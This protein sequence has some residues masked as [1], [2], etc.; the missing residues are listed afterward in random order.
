MTWKVFGGT[1]AD[2]YWSLLIHR[3]QQDGIEPTE[4]N[5]HQQFRTHLHRGISYLAGD[6]SIRSIADLLAK[7]ARRGPAAPEL[8]MRSFGEV[9]PEDEDTDTE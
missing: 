7:V 1:Y 6:R 3:C 2:V 9:E 8:P 5:L 4:D